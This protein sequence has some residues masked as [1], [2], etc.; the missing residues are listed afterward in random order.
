MPSLAQILLSTE[1]D[2]KVPLGPLDLYN[3]SSPLIALISWI[4]YLPISWRKLVLDTCRVQVQPSQNNHLRESYESLEPCIYAHDVEPVR[5]LYKHELDILLGRVLYSPLYL[6]LLSYCVKAEKTYFREEF[7]NE[8]HKSLDKEF[9]AAILSQSFQQNL[10]YTPLYS[11][12]PGRLHSQLT[13]DL[14]PRVKALWNNGLR[15]VLSKIGDPSTLPILPKTNSRKNVGRA[16]QRNYLV[17]EGYDL[18]ELDLSLYTVTTLNLLQH[19]HR[20]GVSIPGPLEMRQAWFFNDLKPRTYYCLG[21]TDFTAGMYIQDIAN[22]FVQ[23][24]PSTNT[25]TRYHVSRIGQLT[26]GQILVTYDYSSFTT[27]LSELRYFLFWLA[28]Q[29]MGTP[30]PLL[31]VREGVQIHDLGEILMEY[32]NVVNHYQEFS[33]ERFAK[34]GDEFLFYQGRN[35]SLGTKGNI[36][37]STTCHGVALAD[38]TGKPDD[39]L[40]VGDDALSAIYSFLLQTFILCVNNLGFINL[41]KFTTI[42][43]PRQ[44][45][46]PHQTQFKFLKRP[47]FVDTEGFPILGTLDFFPSICDALFPNGDGIHTA[48]PSYTVFRAAQTFAM[49]VGRFLNLLMLSDQDVSLCDE[50]ELELI[51]RSFQ[52]VYQRF[53]LPLGGGIPGSFSVADYQV[54]EYRRG[55][56]FLPRVDSVDIFGANWLHELFFVFNGHMLTLPR[57]EA[58]E[59]PPLSIHEGQ[60]FVCSSRFNIFAFMEKMGFLDKEVLLDHVEFTE[61]VMRRIED[62]LSPRNRDND[63]LLCMYTVLYVPSWYSDYALSYLDVD[64]VV[65]DPS[66]AWERLSV[67]TGFQL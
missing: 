45:V 59:S 57:R 49:Q 44:D 54:D 64:I 53:G 42:E 31:D 51:L 7:L 60:T 15:N 20:T 65:E 61:E 16:T 14:L 39:D 3:C 67:S 41:E 52:K 19:Y 17:A 27:S 24:L 28:Q 11:N 22:L 66:E 58:G 36:V 29:C 32:N 6:S 35:G 4:F 43:V 48:A 9:G 5:V 26:Q 18:S 63:D 62:D 38:I 13:G 30:V 2:K 46:A 47:L 34:D 55:T 56:F 50:E 25:G 37:F 23:I 21:G 8:K 33:L 1:S 40:V 10:D 12:M